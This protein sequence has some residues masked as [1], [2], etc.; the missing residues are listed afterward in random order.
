MR[1]LMGITKGR[2]GTVY[3]AI[4]RVPAPLQEAVARVLNNGKSRQAWLKRS[5]ATPGRRQVNFV[6]T[7]KR[8]HSRKPDEQYSIIDACS[9][10]PYFEL[11][12]RGAQPNWDAWGNQAKKDYQPSWPTYPYHSGS[13]KAAMV[14]EIG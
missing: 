12:A 6:A 4:K 10:G 14:T 5:L 11:F 3:Y 9:P 7:R 2:H 8:E 1:L 13:P